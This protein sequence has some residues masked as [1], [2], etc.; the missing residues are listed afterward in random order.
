MKKL[1]SV[2]VYRLSFAGRMEKVKV[3]VKDFPKDILKADDWFAPQIGELCFNDDGEIDVVKNIEFVRAEEPFKAYNRYS[4]ENSK[5]QCNS[6]IV[7]RIEVKPGKVFIF[8]G[9]PFV[10][11]EPL[12]GGYTDKMAKGEEITE[13]EYK[14]GE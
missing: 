14:E 11:Q 9:K 2:S 13:Y 8:K 12:D 5:I 7:I 4:F 1:T 3:K 10:H 6:S